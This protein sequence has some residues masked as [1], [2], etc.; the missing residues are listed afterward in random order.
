MSRTRRLMPYTW[1][2]MGVIS[3][4]ISRSFCPGPRGG[5]GD[6]RGDQ[7][8]RQQ[9]SHDD[10]DRA[11]ERPAEDEPADPEEPEVNDQASERPL[12]ESRP[13]RGVAGGFRLD[14]DP[15]RPARLHAPV[16]FT[17]AVG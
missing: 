6:R 9:G 3:L 10:R 13:D 15:A 14:A 12:H 8:P 17:Q 7:I 4:T 1:M 16:E 2:G 11:L 5:H